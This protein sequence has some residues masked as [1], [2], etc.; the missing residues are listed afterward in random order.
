MTRT[1]CLRVGRP[2][3]IFS[4]DEGEELRQRV[5]LEVV[6]ALQEDVPDTLNLLSR[7]VIK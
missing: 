1:S 6:G 7:L 5:W 2:A 4:G 3:P